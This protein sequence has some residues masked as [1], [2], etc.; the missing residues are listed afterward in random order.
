MQYHEVTTIRCLFVSRTP[1]SHS[2]YP[3]TNSQISWSVIGARHIS[4]R[5]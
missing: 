1:E 2:A 3:T 4:P 5:L